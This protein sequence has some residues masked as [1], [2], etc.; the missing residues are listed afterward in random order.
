MTVSTNFLAKPQDFIRPVFRLVQIILSILIGYVLVKAIILF[1]NPEVNWTPLASTHRAS[2]NVSV[3]QPQNFDFSTDPFGVSNENSEV[4]SEEGFLYD[5]NL[6]VP[7]TS[8]NIRESSKVL[9]R[10]NQVNFDV[11]A[12]KLFEQIRLNPNFDQGRLTG[13]IIQPKGQKN[14]L[15]QFGLQPGD[16]LTAINGES[17]TQ[18]RLDLQ[19]LALTLNNANAVRLSIVRNGRSQTVKIGQ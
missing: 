10:N 18:G 8:L 3:S 2:S 14:V 17:L 9:G 5:P 16:K 15:K 13:Y 11:K 6:D 4:L 12:S 19:E 7:E 1:F